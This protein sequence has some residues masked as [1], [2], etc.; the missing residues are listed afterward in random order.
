MAMLI[1][2][3]IQFIPLENIYLTVSHTDDMVF[4]KAVA[5][6]SNPIFQRFIPPVIKP[7]TRFIPQVNTHFNKSHPIIT[8][9]FMAVKAAEK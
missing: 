6:P 7:V 5:K 3:I 1:L 4:L 2:S 9:A 8:I